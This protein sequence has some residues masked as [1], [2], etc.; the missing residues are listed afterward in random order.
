M[1]RG[2]SEGKAFADL[3]GWRKLRVSGADALAWL[4]DLLSADISDLGPGRAKTSLLLS[5]TGQM[6]ADVTVA[7]TEGSVLLLQDDVQPRAIGDL[8]APYVLSSKVELEDR[9]DD[10]AVLAF[11]GLASPPEAAGSTAST[12]SS[13]KAGSELLVPAGHRERLLGSLH[14]AYALADEDEV[15]AWRIRAGIPRF[16]VDG[17]EADL[18]QECGLEDAIAFHK[19]CYLGQ[20]TMAR[21]RN[22]GHPRRVLLA[23]FADDGV[24]SGDDVLAEG[25][26]VGKVT[27]AAAVGGRT[28]LLAKVRWEAREA[29]LRSASG[30]E[31]VAPS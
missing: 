18:P 7:M 30:Q 3:S 11:P 24:A 14:E 28:A 2:L 27:S 1:V 8:L 20:E 26:S 5:P 29:T 13:L 10:L 25:S 17:S 9:T 6:R 22:F 15:E 21:V 31:L 12:P 4:N 23:L 19:G 16:G